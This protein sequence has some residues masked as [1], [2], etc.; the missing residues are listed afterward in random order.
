[1]RAT[2]V[3]RASCASNEHLEQLALEDAARARAEQAR[4][5]QDAQ[6]EITALRETVHAMASG[7][8]AVANARPSQV[9][10][11]ERAAEQRA[12]ADALNMHELRRELQ[13]FEIQSEA[14]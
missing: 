9:A 6:N 10:E 13:R 4:L 1:M 14:A 3:T 2:S 7:E 11:V 5:A 8:Q 12:N